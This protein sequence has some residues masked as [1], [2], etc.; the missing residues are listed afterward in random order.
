M[1]VLVR[2][3]PQ[4]PPDPPGQQVP[5]DPPDRPVCPSASVELPPTDMF[6]SGMGPPSCGIRTDAYLL[7][8]YFPERRPRSHWTNW[9]T[10][11]DGTQGRHGASRTAGI[12][13]YHWTDRSHRP[14][15]SYRP[16]RSD[17]GIYLPRSHRSYRSHRSH[18]S[19]WRY[20]SY[21]CRRG[22][23]DSWWFCWCYWCD[24]SRRR[25]DLYRVRHEGDRVRSDMER[26]RI[27]SR[28]GTQLT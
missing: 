5:L 18:W 26:D 13:G 9:S 10:R 4:D 20:R 27:T 7:E 14:D 3:V 2:Q 23:G 24:W 6:P 1:V 25:W 22:Y 11:P 21:W 28:V 8:D 15:R 19:N 16:D 17:G 12:Y